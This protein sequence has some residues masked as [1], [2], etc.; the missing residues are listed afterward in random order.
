MAKFQALQ[1]EISRMEVSAA[2]PNQAEALK[3]D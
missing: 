2:N 1:T 3:L